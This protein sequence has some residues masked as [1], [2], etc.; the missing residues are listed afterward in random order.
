MTSA[1]RSVYHMSLPGTGWDDQILG[2]TFSSR[3]DGALV[4][5]EVNYVEAITQEM[6]IGAH[7]GYYTLMR[8][9]GVPEISGA[10]VASLGER[11]KFVVPQPA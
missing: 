8:S 6:V 10:S 1:A 4:Q 3:A 2:V 9:F 5:R 11:G 7:E